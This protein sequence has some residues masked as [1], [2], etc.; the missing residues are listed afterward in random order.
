MLA[1]VPFVTDFLDQF[2]G[3]AWALLVLG[4]MAAAAW[5][6]LFA[7][8][9]ARSQPR[10]PDPGPATMQLGPETPAVANLLVGRWRLS[11]DAVQATLLDLAAR[12]HLGV[13]LYAGENLVIRLRDGGTGDL[14]RYEAQ[15]VD[16]V[17]L[18]ATG[19][20]APIE[21][22]D[23]GGAAAAEGW[24][25]RFR[26]NVIDHAR[27]LGLARGRWSPN[28]L[29]LLATVLAGAAALIALA[30][31]AARI[32]ED[33]DAVTGEK[34]G[35]WDPLLFAGAGWFLASL[36]IGAMGRWIRDTPRGRTACARWLGFREFC[37]GQPALRDAGP[38]AVSV[39][40]RVL[41]Y[42][43]AVGVSHDAV[44]G[45]PLLADDPGSAWTRSTGQWREIRVEYPSRFGFGEAPH[46]V[47]L[48]GLGLSILFGFLAFIAL[49]ALASGARD[50][51]NDSIGDD[52]TLSDDFR[53]LSRFILLIATGFGIALAIGLVRGLMYLF[54]GAMDLGRTV[55]HEG[56]VVKLHAGRVA[57]DD[58]IE[59]ETTAWTPAPGSPPVVRGDRVRVL[60]SPH[61][62]HVRKVEL[63]S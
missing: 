20:S 21:A 38:G 48:R 40:E 35:R 59:E 19:G 34:S 10:L 5:L 8:L 37:R 28:D 12:G 24:W 11:Y 58:G 33:T 23:L 56:T 18:R 51:L 14:T 60:H 7:I 53:N 26:G 25:K 1:A 15:V 42:S 2:T 27:A 32:G 30:F 9:W 41:A 13:E 39:Y 54:R 31:V 52:P 47:F 3:V 22:I 17:R 16:L 44:Q 50:L 36:A 62:W 63:L 49:P 43:A 6:L 45:L 55:A 4:G 29:T 57:L 46:R 61:L